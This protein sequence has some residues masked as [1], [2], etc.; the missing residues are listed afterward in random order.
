MLCGSR[1]IKKYLSP[2]CA[3][4]SGRT[5]LFRVKI[6]PGTLLFLVSLTFAQESKNLHFP[7]DRN[8]SNSYGSSDSRGPRHAVAADTIDLRGIYTPVANP[9][10][11]DP[12][13]PGI[14]SAI[15]CLDTVYIFTSGGS[16][17]WNEFSWNN[18]TPF[19]GDSIQVTGTVTK[20]QDIFGNPYQTIDLLNVEPLNTTVIPSGEKY[21]RQ[22]PELEQNYPNPFNPSTRIRYRISIPGEVRLTVYDCRGQEVKYLVNA[23]QEAGEYTIDFIQAGLSGGIYFYQLQLGDF[24]KAKKMILLH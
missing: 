3:M 14:V 20:H 11:T 8:L 19:P 23:W 24:I 1:K 12:C 17:F 18:Y 13:L 21:V 16:W 5:I 22:S 15:T 10:L 4:N 2:A 9:C 7:P 6:I